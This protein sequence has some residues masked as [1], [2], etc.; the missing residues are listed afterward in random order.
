MVFG[1]A[2]II[3]PSVLNRPLVFR[4]A[5]YVHVVVLH[6]G[7]VI[8]L[9]GDLTGVADLRLY[10]GLL[11]AAAIGLFLINTVRSVQLRSSS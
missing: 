10:G 4:R 1:H 8:R 2:P 5:F 11:N 9:A 7:L 3:F 6:A